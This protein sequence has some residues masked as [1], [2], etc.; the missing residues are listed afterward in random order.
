MLCGVGNQ[1]MENHCHRLACLRLQNDV[2]TI[3]VRVGRRRI[4]C[5]LTSDKSKQRYSLPPTLAQEFV[6]PRH[7]ADATIERSYEMMHRAAGVQCVGG[8]SANSCQHI[9]DA[10]IKF[11]IQG[12]L[13]RLGPF[14][15]RN[16]DVDTN[17]SMWTTVAVVGRKATRLNPA[18]LTPR[19]NNA[20]I[21][22]IFPQPV[23][24]ITSPDFIKSA[25]VF[26]APAMRC[27][28]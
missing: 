10:M 22:H 11:S 3:D 9:L 5:Q 15:V 17:H 16:I 23:L 13:E 8:D 12:V 18:N 1:L 14:A 26:E 20:I 6:C 28:E 27:A 19:P 2:G 4:G 7:R 24:K 25:R 21:D